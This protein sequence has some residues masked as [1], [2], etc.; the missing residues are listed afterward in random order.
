MDQE[1]TELNQQ[2]NETK[3]EENEKEN[4]VAS[5]DQIAESPINSSKNIKLEDVDIS[6][7]TDPHYQTILKI[8]N[9]FGQI[10]SIPN[11]L[12][13]LHKCAGDVL[14]AMH[15]LKTAADPTQFH[16]DFSYRRIVSTQL[17]TESY[18]QSITINMSSK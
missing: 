6:A 12:S 14:D 11:I 18:F 9:Y 15:L 7:E 4:Q 10:Y 5:S 17:K 3:S 8:Y 2:E 13:A 1:K 16:V